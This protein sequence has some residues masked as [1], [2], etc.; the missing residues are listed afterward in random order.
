MMTWESGGI[1]PPSFTSQLEKI[2]SNHHFAKIVYRKLVMDL[3]A[4]FATST[5][6][7]GVK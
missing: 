5:N 2:F 6:L 7:S 1:A 3:V 4:N